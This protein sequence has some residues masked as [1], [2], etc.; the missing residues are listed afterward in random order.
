MRDGHGLRSPYRDACPGP[1]A[2]AGSRRHRPERVA[3][4]RTHTTQSDIDLALYQWPDRPLDLSRLGLLA[5]AMDDTHRP[6]VVIGIGGW[7]PWI[8]GGGWLTV[9]T[10]PQMARPH[11]TVE[12]LTG[13]APAIVVSNH[14]HGD[15]VYG[16]QVF[17]P[18]LS[19]LA[20]TTLYYD[21]TPVLYGDGDGRIQHRQ[22]CGGAMLTVPELESL[23]GDLESDKRR[24]YSDPGT[25][26]ATV[27]TW[28]VHPILATRRYGIDESYSQSRRDFRTFTRVDA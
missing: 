3:G 13:R 28:R 26:P 15:H 4:A 21:H 16:N 8:N 9:R 23:L 27:D 20:A 6:D 22:R 12:R 5:T 24:C 14:R 10:V 18:P 11:A 17:I 19:Y 1:P 25:G 2:R 7:G